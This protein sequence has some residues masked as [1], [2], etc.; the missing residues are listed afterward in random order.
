MTEGS[1]V[2]PFALDDE[3]EETVERNPAAR[4]HLAE[5]VRMAEAIVFAS[6]EPVSERQLVARLPEGIDVPAAMA[7]LQ[8]I[9]ERRGVN[10][11]KVADSWA[12]RTA[13]DLAFLMSRDTIQQKKLSRAA[14]EVLSVI[15]YHQPV[16][17]AEIEDIRGVET[18]KGTL[19]TLMETE[20]VRMRGRRK[21]PGRPVTY[22]TTDK[23]LDHFGLEEIR[24]LP[25]MEELK[26]AGLLS[27]RMPPGFSVPLPPSDP[28]LLTDDEDP[29]TDIDL[30]ELGLLTPRAT[31]D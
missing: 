11:V 14:L 23:F 28:D 15:A 1:N 7:E 10:L 30:E 25:G 12:F 8:R 19:D 22:G 13:G 31:D 26:G 9:Y 27:S 24:D 17:R 2:V 18:S 4:L 5:A 16:T 6:A 21:T 20:W 29:L 3:D